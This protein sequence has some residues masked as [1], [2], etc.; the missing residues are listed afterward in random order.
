MR[1]ARPSLSQS[2]L[3]TATDTI[4]AKKEVEIAAER[5]AEGRR[6]TAGSLHAENF[7]RMVAAYVHHARLHM[8]NKGA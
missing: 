8:L 7:L 1:V 6:V 2:R 3:R 5:N 4:S